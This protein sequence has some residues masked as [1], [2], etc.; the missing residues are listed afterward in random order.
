MSNL[1]NKKSKYINIF[2]RI[3]KKIA[4]YEGIFMIKKLYFTNSILYYFLCILSR[5][6]YLISFSGDYTSSFFN[7]NNT[8]NNFH[9]YV[10]SL[11]CYNLVQKANFSSEK[12]YILNLIIAIFFI[13]RIIN[14]L[15]YIKMILNYKNN[16]K[17]PIPTEFH[18]I[19]GHIVFLFF[20][21]II[22]YL[23]FSYYIYFFPSK[24]IIKLNNTKM[25]AFIFIIINTI[26]IVGY[27]IE[28]YIDIICSNKIYTIS[29]SDAYSNIC[30]KRK[31]R[32]SFAFRC[33]NLS[34]Y[35]YIFVQN[36]ALFLTI[37][38][39]I[40]RRYQVM[41]K[42]I[43]STLLLLTILFLFINK[44]HEYNL[45]NF[46]N[47]LINTLALFC[48][49][50][51]IIDFIVFILEY[52][53]NNKLTEII[54]IITKLFLSFITYLLFRI[55]VNIFLESKITEIL[56]QEK[57]NKDEK[58]YFIN[59]FYYL[60]QI[61]IKI[62]EE[63]KIESILILVKFLNRHINKCDKHA[64]NC[65]ILK[66]FMISE[67]DDKLNNED[68]KDF[69][70]QLLIILNYLFESVFID[71]DFYNN[72]D[73]TIL[74]AEHHCHLKDNPMMAFSTI[75]TLI[76]K[77]NNKFSK[78]QIVILYELC[79][80]Y[81]YFLSAKIMNEMQIEIVKNNTA[82][83]KF[84]RRSDECKNYYNNLKMSYKVKRLISNYIYNEL[85]LLKYKI[86]FEDSLSFQFDE[87]NENISVKIN[88]FNNSTSIDNLYVDYIPNSKVAK[89]KST[90]ENTKSTNL[91]III[92][93]LKKEQYFYRKI[94][95]YIK[96][97][98]IMKGVPVFMLYKYFLFFD[99]FEG[100]K[101]PDEIKN[102]LYESLINAQNSYNGIITKNEYMILKRRYNDQNNRLDSKFYVII[103]LKRE[104]TTKYFT[105]DVSLKLG[106][107]QKDIINET[108]NLL[109][110]SDFCKSHQ[111]SIR[112]LIIGNQLKHRQ[113]K[114]NYFFNKNST[115]LYSAN[116]EA[117]LIYSIS[118]T[119]IVLIESYFNF[120]NEYRFMLNSNLELLAC[121]KNFE[122]EYYLNQK[123]IQTYKLKLMD[124]LKINQDKIYEAFKKEFQK[125][126]HQKEIRQFK[127]EEYFIPQFYSNPEDKNR[128][129]LNPNYFNTAKNNIIS[130]ISSYYNNEEININ[131]NT[132][133]SEDFEEEKF[134]NKKNFNNS[135]K[136]LLDKLGEIIF[137]SNYNKTLNKGT[138]V[139]NIARELIKIP[140]N[141]IM[142][143]NDKI[144][145]NLITS[146]KKLINKLLTK[147]ELSNYLMKITIK[148]SY[149]YDKPFYFITIDDPKKIY[150]NI[151]KK[152]NFE[153]SNKSI[154]LLSTNNNKM[155]IP[156]KKFDKKSRNK[157]LIPKNDSNKI[158][159]NLNE[160]NENNEN[161]D[162]KK[163][164]I[165]KIEGVRKV[166]NKDKFISIIKWSLSIVI[167]CILLLFIL[168]ISF[169]LKI[170]NLVHIIINSYFCHNN[171]RDITLQIHSELLKTYYED[172][173]I[174]ENPLLRSTQ[175][176]YELQRIIV[177]LKDNYHDFNSYFNIY[178]L[179][180]GHDIDIIYKKRNFT[181]LRGYWQEIKYESI[182][183][184]E[185]D[186]IIYNIFKINLTN[187]NS[188][189][190]KSDVK[191]LLFFKERQDT[192]IKPYTSFI[193]LL[194]YL[195]V[196]Y[197][198]VYK[199][200]FQEIEKEI[201]SIFQQQ[202]CNRA[203]LILIEVSGYLLIFLFYIIISFYLYYSNEII[204]KNIIFLFL[205]FGE[206]YY[207]KSRLN[208]NIIS[209]KLQEFQNLI[210]DFNLNNFE[211]FSKF[212][213]NI[214]KNKSELFKPIRDIKNIFNIN[215][216]NSESKNDSESKLQKK[217]S[218]KR[219]SMNKMESDKSSSKKEI[220]KQKTKNNAFGK[221]PQIN[222]GKLKNKINDN[223][224]N[225]VVGSFSEFFKNKMNK[226][227]D[228][229][230][231]L[232]K[233]S[234]N[235]SN[236]FSNQNLMSSKNNLSEKSTNRTDSLK[237]SEKEGIEN[238]QDL[239]INKSNKEIILKIKI[240]AIMTF[241]IILILILLNFYKLKLF[242]DFNSSYDSFFN[243]YNVLSKRVSMLF[244]YTNIFRILLI[245]P[246]DERKKALENIMENLIEDYEDLNRKYINLLSSNTDKYNEIKKL[247]DI[248]K[249]GNNVSID[250]LQ[251]FFCTD[252]STCTNYLSSEANI[253]QNGIDFA[254]KTCF[255]Q[256]SNFYMD[257][258][259][260]S[261]KTDIDLIKSE[262][263]N[264]PHFKFALIG[265]SLVSMFNQIRNR[266][267]ITFSI[268]ELNFNQSFYK[269]MILFNVLL[270]S[271]VIIIFL[272][273]NFYVFISISKYI[274]PIKDS[275][276]RINCSFFYIK[277][278]NIE[279][280]R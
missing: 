192:R 1:F 247:I 8:L 216:K 115:V 251:N 67:N 187:S 98:D 183:S 24:F 122:E 31:I 129:L 125:I 121:S 103:E 155:K 232:L 163:T 213:E 87:Y 159:D 118:K 102:Q 43:I 56:F 19:M 66:T 93:L 147:N 80:K 234:S 119:F 88:F 120:E 231:E 154:P 250:S 185:V 104:L 279:K 99:V 2:N 230:N 240:F 71:Y 148:F 38:K 116:I 202:I 75:L 171:V 86:I 21:F 196:N 271:Y 180:I 22:E 51:I 84:K 6:I 132:R 135:I 89:R 193:K 85:K 206:K 76:Q 61:M 33:S 72:F 175:Y 5:F 182:Y 133:S 208:N 100:G 128:G 233:N 214:N 226:N 16:N 110:P 124:I 267:Y 144:N 152:I 44:I 162:D 181:K 50:S 225:Q 49:Y 41:L 209:L 17:W 189:I 201:Y 198:F 127:T 29:F 46:I 205:D 161:N 54:Y 117:T 211:K 270:I 172:Y 252:I 261:N 169:Q 79:Q 259:K 112:H 139:E 35:I 95:E 253:F 63:N 184:S 145:Y 62:K 140:D 106:F 47:S 237:N 108:I 141:D 130:K 222:S 264:S 238:F 176:Q 258:K 257:Y 235:N 268:D 55:K 212:L 269:K 173:G 7:K 190:A 94:I 255:T 207:E 150:L 203:I 77:Q 25:L 243:D 4:T 3:Q 263:I 32:K 137:H 245:F 92:Y 13:I 10:K 101:M 241:I 70:S 97:L 9:Q 188:S 90:K 194:Y 266:I 64:C 143:E 265:N 168:T 138:F 40:N 52:R 59:S 126:H 199:D 224:Y 178:N 167:I 12:Y 229:S 60:H 15:Y 220:E 78:F 179:E 91:Y 28:N 26:L 151:S 197:E 23:S 227:V 248:L 96:E 236:Y 134:I 82:F 14:Y 254:I 244:Y 260:L 165:N 239:L 272:F 166:I 221:S 278:F 57:N 131:N 217:I 68:I 39:Y 114:Q 276:Y 27:N 246:L 277:K 18:I 107:Q 142:M 105:E 146:S 158:K 34:L 170:T 200:I 42:I 109:L 74:L 186:F 174:I 30:E 48:F 136:D 111:N 191:N 249:E 153:N 20:P 210:E 215:I 280:D 228:A 58:K 37:E 160:K 53:M 81:I 223:S 149:Y 123:I 219:I 274:E 218:S 45:K 73:L 36:F 204:I 262:I 65:K 156:K 273:I 83:L 195:N 275:S 11:T 256:L 157:N 164:I 113:S 242:L 69:N 177:K